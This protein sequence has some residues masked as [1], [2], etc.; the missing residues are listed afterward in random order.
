M[1][2]ASLEFSQHHDEDDLGVVIDSKRGKDTADPSFTYWVEV[3]Y[4]SLERLV[5]V[6]EK[7][8]KENV[9]Q[10]TF[11]CRHIEPEQDEVIHV[12]FLYVYSRFL[13]KYRS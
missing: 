4:H 9:R 7:L 8:M 6:C 13:Y 5:P 1:T 12:N 11:T 10:H 3:Y 2:T